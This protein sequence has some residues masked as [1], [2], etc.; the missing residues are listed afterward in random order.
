MTN[1]C[2]KRRMF[3][4]AWTR[5]RKI[6]LRALILSLPT[7]AINLMVQGCR[8]FR[9]ELESHRKYRQLTARTIRKG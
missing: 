7:L 5:L 6:F 8:E 9:P 1:I 3:P 4:A 2:K